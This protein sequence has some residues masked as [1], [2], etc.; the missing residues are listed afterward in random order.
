[1]FVNWARGKVTV[2]Y[3]RAEMVCRLQD[4][5]AVIDAVFDEM[6]AGMARAGLAWDRAEDYLEHMAPGSGAAGA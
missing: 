2:K 3:R 5:R 6:G 4:G 1:M